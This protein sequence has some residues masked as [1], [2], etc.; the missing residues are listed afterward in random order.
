MSFTKVTLTNTIDTIKQGWVKFNTL[1]DDLSSNKGASLIG[2]EDVA[3]NLDAE[4]VEAGIAEV[5]VSGVES[6]RII[7]MFNEDPDTTTGLTWG[8]KAGR[9]RFHQVVTDV[10][11]G[12]TGLIDNATNYVEI[13]SDGTITRNIT[14]FNGTRIPLREIVTSGGVQTSSTDK[15]ALFSGT[16]GSLAS[17]NDLDG[18]SDGIWYKR[19]LSTSIEAGTINLTDGV[20]VYGELPVAYTIADVTADN[21]Q[22]VAWLTDAGI[23]AVKDQVDLATDEVINKVLDNIADGALYSRVLTADFSADHIMLSACAGM[24]DDIGEGIL[25]GKVNLSSISAGNIVLSTCSGN[26][27]D[28]ANGE[29]GKVNTSAIDSGRIKLSAWGV[30]GTLDTSFT[31]AK[32]LDALADE[33]SSHTANDAAHYSGALIITSYTA[34]K[35]TD[36]LADE[37][38]ANNQ[39]LGWLIGSTG[40][41]TISSGGKLKINTADA[42]E[43]MAA[44]NIKVLNGGDI[45]LMQ[46]GTVYGLSTAIGSP[47]FK[48]TDSVTSPSWNNKLYQIAS[49]QLYLD[50]DTATVNIRN[51]QDV[52]NLSYL[53]LSRSPYENFTLMAKNVGSYVQLIGRTQTNYEHLSLYDSRSGATVFVGYPGVELHKG[54]GEIKI[55]SLS[56][57]AN[58][59][60]AVTGGLS[61]G[62]LYRTGGNPDS[63]C[64]VH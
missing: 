5:S 27:D 15:R 38:N 55:P 11:A 16:S 51:Y 59:A 21:P 63:V 42:L 36:A 12:T 44:G 53:Q 34:A 4:D 62:Q 9:V 33:T 2:L 1:I 18:V 57:Y 29:Y 50:T 39:H 22:D 47:A 61:V 28:I 40:E 14:A 58:N 20:G 7:E 48:L 26:L 46:G 31:A 6:R 37:T 17:E 24:L 13:Q 3:G 23:L 25:Y 45:V 49:G 32:C 19:V 10:V 60:A 41:L 43:I 56:S 35:C 30:V 64:V 54:S 8:Y 52:N